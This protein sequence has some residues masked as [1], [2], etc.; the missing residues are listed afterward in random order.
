M[1]R[2]FGSTDS[3]HVQRDSRFPVLYIFFQIL[4]QNSLCGE[5]VYSVPQI[6]VTDTL[7]DYWIAVQHS[8]NSALNTGR[9][10]A[11]DIPAGFQQTKITVSPKWG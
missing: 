11:L 7:S 6:L 8:D 9:S 1:K 5:V 4:F 10:V 2:L 3:V